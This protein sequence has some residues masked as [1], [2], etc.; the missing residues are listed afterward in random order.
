MRSRSLLWLEQVD[1][2][3]SEALG[4]SRR[5]LDFLRGQLRATGHVIDTARSSIDESWEL[6][7]KLRALETT[8]YLD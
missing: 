6:L 2:G 5:H 8:P 3:T 1:L 4:E 7:A